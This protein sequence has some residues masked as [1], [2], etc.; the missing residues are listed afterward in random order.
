MSTNNDDT[1]LILP[2][3][4]LPQLTPFVASIS[5]TSSTTSSS[6]DTTKP[7]KI[8]LGP[9]LVASPFTPENPVLPY[10]TGTLH[11]SNYSKRPTASIN[12]TP[13]HYHPATNDPVLVTLLR[14]TAEQFIVQLTP[15]T[16]PAIIPFTS[17]VINNAGTTAAVRK[18]RPNIPLGAT[19]YARV[20]TVHKHLEAV[21]LSVPG[22]EFGEVVSQKNKSSKEPTSTAQ[23]SSAVAAARNEVT[24]YVTSI[25]QPMTKVLLSDDET[26]KV[27]LS[28]LSGRIG[29]EMIVGKNGRV[30]IDA[31]TQREVIKVVRCF[32]EFD[33][34]EPWNDEDGGV[35]RVRELVGRICG[36]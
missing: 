32:S 2:G 16:P 22:P 21:E 18:S 19:I 29:F 6:A 35:K 17:Y 4:P 9:G 14:S 5:D 34:K 7:R 31:S 15:Y 12:S 13:R 33:E 36:R 27:F 10:I 3:D 30:W 26:G 25:S 11:L 8:R 20:A 28:A 1:D 24:P 23:S